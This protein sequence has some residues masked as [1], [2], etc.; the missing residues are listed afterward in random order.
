MP[1][2]LR[3]MIFGLPR[4]V[5]S[6]LS[7][8]TFGTLALV[9]QENKVV[10]VRQSY[11]AGWQSPRRPGVRHRLAEFVGEAPQNPYW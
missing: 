10:V 1:S 8:M 7:P 11:S 2:L 5:G 4:F 9:E 6:I 3:Q